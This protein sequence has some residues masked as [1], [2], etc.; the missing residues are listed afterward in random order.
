M[1]FALSTLLAF[2]FGFCANAAD[3]LPHHAIYQLALERSPGGSVVAADGRMDYQLADACDAWATAQRLD[4]NI[5]N[6]DGTVS[7]MVSDYVTWE[8]KDGGLLRFRLRQTSNQKMVADVEGEATR[9][10]DGTGQIRYT[11]PA[12][13]MVPLPR[14]TLFPMA[15]T[16]ALLDDAAK[17]QKF[18][19]VPLFDGTDENGAEDSFTVLGTVN[20]DRSKPR[21][22]PLADIPNSQVTINFFDRTDDGKDSGEPAYD[23]AMRYWQNGV[24][25]DVAMDFG[26]FVVKGT[27][28]KLSPNSKG[29]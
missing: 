5:V 17:G 20:D 22:P 14:G 6:N 10:P 24:S 2:G 18:L 19:A 11:A 15:Q 25:D 23:V 13:K 28:I 3:L 9:H 8:Q 1:R 26:D 16:V 21:F 12:N 29:C 7:H 4:L 27:I